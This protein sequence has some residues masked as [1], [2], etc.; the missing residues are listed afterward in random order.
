MRRHLARRSLAVMAAAWLAGP[1]TS[2]RA[3]DKPDAAPA[4]QKSRFPAAQPAGAA[5]GKGKDPATAA[6]PKGKDAPAT[7]PAEEGP[8]D[9]AGTPVDELRKE[10]EKLRE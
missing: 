2:A 10:Y 1:A 8:A 3:Q 9:D 6:A 7:A 4:G 5:P